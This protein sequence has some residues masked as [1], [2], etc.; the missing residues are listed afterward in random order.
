M[1]VIFGIAHYINQ[2]N[3]ENSAIFKKRKR[4]GLLNGICINNPLITGKKDITDQW[5]DTY[6]IVQRLYK[7]IHIVNVLHD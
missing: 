1:P 4:L 2:L 7:H 6:S 5:V 3:F